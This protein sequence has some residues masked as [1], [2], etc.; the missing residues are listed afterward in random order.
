MANERKTIAFQELHIGNNPTP[1]PRTHRVLL[2][3]RIPKNLA[4]CPP[5]YLYPY[6]LILY[7]KLIRI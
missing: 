6:T 3:K 7:K 4:Q 1:G 5:K 2:M